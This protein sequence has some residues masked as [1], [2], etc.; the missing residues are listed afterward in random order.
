MNLQNRK[1]NIEN[2]TLTGVL[3]AFVIVLQIIALFTRFSAFSITLVLIPI[4]IGAAKCGVKAA[5]WLGFVFGVVVLLSGD[6]NAFLS[7]N[8]PGTIITVISK[9]MLAGFITSIVYKTLSKRNEKLAIWVASIT[10][11]I[12]N[13][14]VFAIGC[15]SFFIKDLIEQAAK[16]GFSNV[17]ALIFLG[18]IGTNFIIEVLIN[19]IAGPSL[20]RVIKLLKKGV[21]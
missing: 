5:T 17:T 21:K 10:C 8:I 4:V 20:L 6:A 12:V 15:Y 9:G 19:I 7:F 14:G 1:Q 13:S 16:K 11:P 3:T 18:F 2:L